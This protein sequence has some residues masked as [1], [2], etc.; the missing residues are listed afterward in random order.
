ME[1][2]E[3]VSLDRLLNSQ[4]KPNDDQLLNIVTQLCSALFHAH[5]KGIIHRD[6]KPANILIG[7]DSDGSDL[8]KLVDFGIAKL[9]SET[10]PLCCSPGVC[11]EPGERRAP[12]NRVF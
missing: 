6:V 10:N 1:Y 2:F 3:G 8:V 12:V 7:R 5:E 11:G 9:M 4:K